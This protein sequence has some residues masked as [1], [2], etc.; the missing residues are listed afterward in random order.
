LKMKADKCKGMRDLLPQ[1]MAKFRKVE[2]V[3]RRC[4]S[5]WGYEEV[6]TPT[7]EYLHLFTAVGTLTPAMLG[8]V[9]SFLDWD[10]WS[11]ERVVLRPEGTIPIARLYTENLTGD[12]TC[13]LS[14]VGN[15]FTFEETGKERR[16]QWQCGVELI[17]AS[18]PSADAEL[19]LL[20]AEI[21]DQL[22]LGPLEIS[23]SHAGLIKGLIAELG[24]DASEQTHI[25]DQVLE[26]NIKALG[27]VAIGDSNLKKALDFLLDVKGNSPGF[28]QNIKSLLGKALP[29]LEPSLDDMARLAEYLDTMGCRYQ[30]DIAS[31]RGFEYYTGAMFQFYISGD[32][33]GGGGRYDDLISLVGGPHIPASGFALFAGQLMD[34]LEP[35]ERTAPRILVQ[36][37]DGDTELLKTCIQVASS[38]RDAGYSSALDH[39]DADIKDYRWIITVSGEGHLR[40]RDQSTG[41]ERECSSEAEIRSAMEDTR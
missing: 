24:L 39:G 1:D 14:Y 33:V 40:F 5:Q 21:V 34:L 11:G 12:Q 8:R 19:I 32:R 9:Y 2:G 17:G 18:Q 30:I 36:T 13:R 3:F 38:L 25:F 4:S 35:E 15:I 20:A 29:K 6:R 28:L 26:G 37:E 10:G 27:D 16:E 7:L 41:D 23:L 22:G 31:G